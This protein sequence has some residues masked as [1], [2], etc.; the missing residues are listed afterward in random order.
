MSSPWSGSRKWCLPIGVHKYE[1]ASK[2]A[3]QM[4]GK[5]VTGHA[6]VELVGDLIKIL[7]EELCAF[8]RL[9]RSGGNFAFD[10]FTFAL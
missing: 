10:C 7:L 5:P 6:V 1:G 4:E 9:A 8:R 3:G 2:V